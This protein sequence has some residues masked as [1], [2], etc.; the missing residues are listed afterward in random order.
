MCFSTQLIS[1]SRNHRRDSL[2][3]S[4]PASLFRLAVLLPP[5]PSAGCSKIC[6]LPPSPSSLSWVFEN[7]NHYTI[8][9]EEGR[10][11]FLTRVIFE[12]KVFKKETSQ[13]EKRYPPENLRT[14]SSTSYVSNLMT[15]EKTII[16][17]RNRKQ[18][19]NKCPSRKGMDQVKYVSPFKAFSFLIWMF[20]LAMGYT[21]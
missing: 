5:P 12:I 16:F 3:V 4:D 17:N 18:Y 20:C 7:F 15:N 19:S 8:V 1:T 14:S 13:N 11:A 21:T 6:H 9:G 2:C 10:V